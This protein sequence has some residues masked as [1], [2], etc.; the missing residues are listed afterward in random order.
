M[1]AVEPTPNIKILRD[2]TKHNT[3]TCPRREPR[4][5]VT[6]NV[7]DEFIL[8]GRIRLIR[9]T[10]LYLVTLFFPHF[11][12]PY[13]LSLTSP[14]TLPLFPASLVPVTGLLEGQILQA[15]SVLSPAVE[16]WSVCQR[17]CCITSYYLVWFVSMCFMSV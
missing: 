10:T 12:T 15:S 17:L 13:M 6:L 16:A 5:H 11:F 8:P 7:D 3:Y 1:E 4:I 9:P 2:Q 14:Y